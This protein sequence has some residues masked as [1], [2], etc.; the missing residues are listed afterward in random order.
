MKMH[1]MNNP[2]R[3]LGFLS[4]GIGVA[5]GFFLIFVATWADIEANSYDF[6]RLANAG[7]GGLRCP[8]LMTPNE[9]ST[10]SLNVSNPTGNQISPAIKVLISTRLLPEEF[11]EGFQLMPGEAKRLEWTVDSEHI[12]LG[13]F[14]LAKVLL[15]SAYPLPSREA[16]CGIFVLNLPVTGRVLVPVLMVLSFLSMGWGLYNL[17]RFGALHG[18]LSKYMGSITFL[19]IIISLGLV[20][21]FVG[22]WLSSL[23][24]LVVALLLI[25][26]LL[27]SLLTDKAR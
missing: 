12:D 22:G 5:A 14:I 15:Y 16:S 20:L 3:L 24:V 17:S 11:L 27:S 21:S 19:A 6:P 7:L 8:V 23:L 2:K 10:I 26:I 25:I 4:Y 18:R 9:T 1:N 13:N